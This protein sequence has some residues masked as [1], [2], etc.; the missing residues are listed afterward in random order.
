M[1]D[2][3]ARFHPLVNLIFYIVVLGITM[4]QMQLGLVLISLCS[5]LV[6]F[7]CLKKSEGAGYLLVVIGIF[8]IS[9][10][11][12]PLFSHR[13]NTLLFYLFTG[14]PV[15]LESILYGMV[16]SAIICGMLLWLS[17]FHQVMEM[18]RLLGAIGKIMPH[19]ALL[20][21]MIL[22]FIPKYTKHQKEVSRYNEAGEER[23]LTEKIKRGSKIFSITTTWA[24]ENSIYTADSMKARGFG[25]KRRTSYSN[26]RIEGRDMVVIV[27]IVVLAGCVIR[28]L[29]G[30][31]LY[32]YYYPYMV[33]KNNILVYV[34][35]A[36]LCLTPV[37]INIREEIRWH[38]LK[39]KI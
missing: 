4:F 2:E 37:L 31:E 11:I 19:I 30:E 28:M 8:F 15:T 17:T 1:K 16:S 18:E 14:N 3:F 29:Q 23:S 35:Y 33:N 26:Y 32:T 22:R 36:L 12:N 27:W 5:A 21:T 13:G 7:F 24:L 38:R 6:Y 34:L 9:S 25:V 39:S 20:I 10:L